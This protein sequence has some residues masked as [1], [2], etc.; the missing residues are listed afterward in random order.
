[1]ILIGDIGN[2]DI[3][4]A[5]FDKNK[6]LIFKKRFNPI[7]L[8]FNNLSK[9]FKFLNRYFKYIDKILFCSVVPKKFEKIKK[10]LENI[11]NKKCYE[12]KK[13]K[14]EKLIQVK[15]DKNQVGSDRLANTIS[16][17]NKKKILSL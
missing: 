4:I 1:M 13:I 2:T 8:N 17:S 15:V 16:V 12:L 3:K 5:L 11:T 9:H 6:K 7:L 14:I 10:Y